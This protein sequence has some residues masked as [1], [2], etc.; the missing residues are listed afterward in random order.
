MYC[1]A[2]SDDDL[3]MVLFLAAPQVDLSSAYAANRVALRHALIAAFESGK[4]DSVAPGG[5]LRRIEMTSKDE[6]QDRCMNGEV[7]R[8]TRDDTQ[9]CGELFLFF[10]LAVKS[11]EKNAEN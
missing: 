5:L 4:L 7:I 9:F 11:I 10:F 8:R 3:D 1:F 2:V 6:V